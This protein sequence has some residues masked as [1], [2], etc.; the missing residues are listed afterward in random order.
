MECD[1]DFLEGIVAE[2]VCDQETVKLFFFV[3]NQLIWSF[4]TRIKLNTSLFAF[5]DSRDA[6]NRKISRELTAEENQQESSSIQK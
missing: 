1:P 2:P 6:R 4:K 5:W 3:L